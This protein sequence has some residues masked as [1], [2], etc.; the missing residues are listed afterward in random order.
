MPR[1]R[2]KKFTKF[3]GKTL[4]FYEGAVQLERFIPMPG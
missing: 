3:K 4:L 2:P 1:E